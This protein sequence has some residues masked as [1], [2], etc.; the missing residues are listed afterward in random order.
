[1]DGQEKA[2]YLIF[3]R[4][5][6]P[7]RLRLGN[8]VMSPYNPDESD[9]YICPY[10]QLDLDKWTGQAMEEPKLTIDRVDSN[11]KGAFVKLTSLVGGDVSRS[12]GSS[13]KVEGNNARRFQIHQAT[14]FLNSVILS[15]PEAK[16]WLSSRIALSKTMLLLNRL[17]VGKSRHPQ[18]WMVTGVQMLSNATVYSERT[19]SAKTGA[20]IQAPTP[21]LASAVLAAAGGD[22]K[23]AEAAISSST[24]GFT[25]VEYQ[26]E[27]ERVWA[28]QFRRL[29]LDFLDGGASDSDSSE[30]DVSLDGLLHL[31]LT[32]MKGGAQVADETRHIAGVSDGD[33]TMEDGKV[34]TGKE[35][36][37][38]LRTASGKHALLIG[39]AEQS[40]NG[41]QTDLSVMADLLL[42]RGFHVSLCYGSD[43]TRRGIIGAW[44][45]LIK[46]I[47]KKSRDAVVVYYS[48]H[49]GASEPEDHSKAERHQYILPFDI[50]KTTNTNFHGILDVEL[51]LFVNRLTDR[52]QN[53]TIITDCCHSERIARDKPAIG[54]RAWAPLTREAIE[55]HVNRLRTEGIYNQ[56]VTEGNK[57][58]VRL[59]A[60]ESEKVAF[61]GDAPRVVT[62][63]GLGSGGSKMGRL[64][65]ELVLELN[66]IG[67]RRTTWDAVLPQLRLKLEGAHMQSQ[68]PSVEGPRSRV[69]F[70]L[71][72]LEYWGKLRVAGSRDNEEVTLM[73]GGVLA[74]VEVG[75]EYAILPLTA[76]R[77]DPAAQIAFTKVTDV[78]QLKAI[79]NLKKRLKPSYTVVNKHQERFATIK[80][81]GDRL[82]LDHG[83]DDPLL[84][85]P[86]TTKSVGADPVNDLIFQ[87]EKLVKADQLLNLTEVCADDALDDCQ[88]LTEVGLVK[89]DRAKKWQ[90]GDNQLRVVEGQCPYLI[91]KNEGNSTLYATVFHVSS[92]G[93]IEWLSHGSPSGAELHKGCEYAPGQKSH[94]HRDLRRNMVQWQHVWPASVPRRGPLDENF[95]VVLTSGKADL[96]FWESM[97]RPS[98]SELGAAKELRAGYEDKGFENSDIKFCVRRIPFKLVP[99]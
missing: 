74:G 34:M 3:G 15:S 42:G 43:A 9:P 88:V 93:T 59:V 69:L 54:E 51:S 56:V 32:G 30:A 39:G 14:E 96:G 65:R 29:K 85:Y 49:G 99:R 80:Q 79:D 95:V 83:K 76:S 31:G 68:R 66:S 75:D 40:L 21:E 53:V 38:K 82:I 44:N 77:P 63:R 41:V 55:N 26:H 5:H 10:T 7:S 36:F 72:T 37:E 70:S 24:G 67:D 60:A 81:D 4:G 64:T 89:H 98:V 91:I 94:G 87:L 92:M 52:T 33:M 97:R 47:P 2:T 16:K 8:L 22:G 17:K 1:M 50:E 23:L 86:M 35:T 57:Y 28:A 71:E 73:G 78:W 25:N 19:G 48:G 20:N 46:R 62:S 45:A 11:D 90:D 18:I 27:G 61:E 12:K 6:D 58:A 13:L 84:G